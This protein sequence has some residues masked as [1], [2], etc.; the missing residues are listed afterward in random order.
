MVMTNFLLLDSL[1]S[2]TKR[3]VIEQP[4]P[5]NNPDEKYETVLFLPKGES[6]VGEGGLRTK[7]LFKRN[8]A[9]KPLVTVITVV[10]NGAEHL[11]ETILSVL[12]Q[13][14]DNVEY[15]IVD[16]GSTDGTL[17]IV[18]KYEHAIDYWVS[19][20]DAGIYDAM[21]KGVCL[22]TGNLI[23]I[24]NADDW[25]E[26]K[27]IE[28]SVK[29]SSENQGSIIHGVLRYYSNNQYLFSRIGRSNPE[30]NLKAMTVSHP[31][32]FVPV[33][34]YKKIGIF[35]LSYRTIADWDFV[36]RCNLA[37]ISFYWI[38][39]E[40]SNFRLG[41][42]SSSWSLSRVCENWRLR[43]S[44]GY[45]WSYFLF[46]I[47]YSKFVLMWLL[48]VLGCYKLYKNFRHR[49]SFNK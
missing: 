15:I 48:K 33:S 11:E 40:F 37:C 46:V 29:E 6:R 4:L 10:F 17:D 43:N 22:A 23:G 14:Y 45:K 3:V 8:D 27:T 42:A 30:A 28:I 35:N 7:G 49:I 13:I 47:E 12:N 31:T 1:F 16:G 34:C 19:E 21:N 9:D 36:I 26:E 2:T 5:S 25:Y 39:Y 20:K 41:G 24:I 18:R 32:M 44:Y 38:N